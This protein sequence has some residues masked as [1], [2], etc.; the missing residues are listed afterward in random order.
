[1]RKTA[2]FFLLAFVA[3]T[4]QKHPAGI[5]NIQIKGSDTEVNLVLALAERFMEQEPKASIAV[6]GGGSGTGIAALLN[7]KT[8]IAN[9]SRPMDSTER[10]M[11]EQRGIHP[12]ALVIGIDALAIVVHKDNPIDRLNLSEI[13]RIFSGEIH[14]WAQIGGPRQEISLYGRQSNSGTFLFFREKVVQ[15]DYS[16]H[17]KQMNG[18]AQ[19]V[20]ALS[21]DP[22]GIGYAGIGYLAQPE[23]NHTDAFKVIRITAGPGSSAYSPFEYADVASGRYPITRPLYQY[24]NATPQGAL[25]DFLLFAFGPEGQAIVRQNGYYPIAREQYAENLRQLHAETANE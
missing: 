8:S 1:M 21:T 16:P 22:A 19:L 13:G 25:L 5:E 3:W 20:E 4:C 7:G 2:P 14:N 23:K 24:V 17:L 6:T 15:A 18:T 9:A 10:Q 12:L 11:A